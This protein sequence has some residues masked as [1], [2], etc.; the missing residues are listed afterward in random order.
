MWYVVCGMWCMVYVVRRTNIYL[1][2][3]QLDLLSQLARQR[4]GSVAELVREA[5]DVWLH[6]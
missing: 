5:I 2:E 3:R 6:D 4:D 1:E